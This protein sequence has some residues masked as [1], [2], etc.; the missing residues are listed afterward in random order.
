MAS[1][2]QSSVTA[3]KPV[4]APAPAADDQSAMMAWFDKN[5]KL[6][7]YGAVAIAVLAVGAWLFIE[8]GKRKELAGLEALDRARSAFESGNLPVAATEFQRVA[9]SFSGTEAGYAAELAVNE[10]RLASGQI[11]I[12]ADE[13]KKF[14]ERNPPAFYASG[15]W[16]MRGG[17]LENLKK[18]D[19]AAQAYGKGAE[20]AQ[21]DY[22][23]VDGLL[24]QVRAL[25]LVGKDKEAVAV[26]RGI[27]SK[28]G[29][30]IP[31]VAE[32]EVRLAEWTK[33]VL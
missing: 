1:S 23:K 29:R 20:L 22:R 30:D 2:V 3:P 10:V 26:L 9:Q 28:F 18:F 5:R 24:G 8:T 13:L 7:T 32:A 4:P 17:A 16:N 33:G 15:A 11:Q 14:A 21:E 12:A 31:G 19:E 27:V 6:V 25:R